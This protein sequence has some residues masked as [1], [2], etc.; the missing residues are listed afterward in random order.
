MNAQQYN[1]DE[2]P[3]RKWKRVGMSHSEQETGRYRQR[4]RTRAAIVEAAARL[5]QAGAT[6]SVSDIAEAADVSRRTVYL[7]FPTLEQLLI[8]ATVGA[9]SSTVAVDTAL[10]AADDGGADAQTRVVAMIDA[11]ATQSAETLPLGRSLVKLTIDTPPAAPGVPKRGYRR[12]G[13]IERA[14][15]PLR[16]R[17][18]SERYERLVSSLAMVIGWEALVVLADLRGLDAEDQHKTMVWAAQALIAA[19]IAET[20]TEGK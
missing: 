12:V 14:T 13:W 7:Y 2:S 16:P 18:T 4:R 17:L 20:K 19:A 10:D 6:P 1:H 5:L 9:L 3:G 15:E 11:M 8:D